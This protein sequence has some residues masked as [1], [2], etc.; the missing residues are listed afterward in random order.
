M[1]LNVVSSGLREGWEKTNHDFHRGSRLERTSWASHSCV[2]P[3]VSPSPD[4]SSSEIEPPISLWK[5]EGGALEWA[6]PS[7]LRGLNLSPHPS[8]EGRG[9]LP[10]GWVLLRANRGGEG[11]GGGSRM[12][13]D[14]RISTV[15]GLM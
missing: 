2:P 11:E 8:R 15:M 4:P 5:G 14:A 9:S 7:E 10:A 12:G 6:F 1:C 3:H 13:E